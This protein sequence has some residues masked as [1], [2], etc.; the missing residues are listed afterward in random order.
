[1]W[2]I[3]TEVKG[4]ACDSLMKYMLS[5][6]V[7]C[8][9]KPWDMVMLWASAS[10]QRLSCTLCVAASCACVSYAHAGRA[11]QV[12]TLVTSLNEG[13]WRPRPEL[14]RRDRPIR[15]QAKSRKAGGRG[16]DSFF[17]FKRVSKSCKYLSFPLRT[18][19][20]RH[21]YR[22]LIGPDFRAEQDNHWLQRLTVF[23]NT[24]SFLK[25]CNHH[26]WMALK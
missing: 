11:L 16:F 8:G 19:N 23:T 22:C 3:F 1:M 2:H 18:T 6:E 7:N 21:D 4:Y 10:E 17:F 5:Y 20:S 24:F 15:T 12:P 25:L 26:I 14:G 9:W 13:H